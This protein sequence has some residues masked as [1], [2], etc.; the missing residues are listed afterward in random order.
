MMK[1]MVFGMAAAELV[2]R[3]P[4][5]V[6]ISSSSKT[7]A[8]AAAQLRR[9]Q[10]SA[11]EAIRKEVEMRAEAKGMSYDDYDGSDDGDDMLYGEDAL[12]HE[13]IDENPTIGVHQFTQVHDEDPV[14]PEAYEGE[15]VESIDAND[16]AT[17]FGEDA[18]EENLD[19]N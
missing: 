13:L 7:K 9:A 3:A 12:E 16:E 4:E 5:F 1:F 10:F 17:N 18:A 15:D 8:K 11:E 6:Q 2:L 19:Q 14:E